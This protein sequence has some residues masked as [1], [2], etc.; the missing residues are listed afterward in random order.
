MF[1]INP[2][3][4]TYLQTLAEQKQWENFH[5][6]KKTLVHYLNEIQGYDY[7]LWDVSSASDFG[8]QLTL[9][10]IENLLEINQASLQKHLMQWNDLQKNYKINK[11]RISN[12][13]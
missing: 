8:K 10:N 6:W 4:F 13:K 9:D 5:L 7:N 12:S 3:H 1:Y 11:P 2:Y